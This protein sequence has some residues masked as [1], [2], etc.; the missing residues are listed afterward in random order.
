MEEAAV[1]RGETALP[2]LLSNLKLTEV[3]LT[4]AWHCWQSTRSCTNSRASRETLELL[5]LELF[6]QKFY[7]LR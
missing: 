2:D 3:N 1:D 7:F 6:L 5:L 4:H